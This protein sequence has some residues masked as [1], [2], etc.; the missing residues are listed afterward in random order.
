MK[1]SFDCIPCLVKQTIEAAR[2]SSDEPDLQR[3][4][5]NQVLHYLQEAD[6]EV[7]PPELGKRIFKIMQQLTGCEDPYKDLKFRY[8]KSVMSK[9]AELKR[10]IYLSDDPVYLAA[11]LALSGNFYHLQAEDTQV[12]IREYVDLI[13]RSQFAIDNYFSFLDDLGS[14]RNILYL[15]DN[16]GEIVFDKLFI[17]VLKRF[18][19]ERDHAFTV[20]VRG[21][22]IINDATME[23]ARLI[24]L[25]EVAQVIDNGDNAPAT[26]LHH[27]SE[28]MRDIYDR[29]D[30]V[31]SKGQGNFETLHDEQKLIYFMF[32]V[33][34]PVIA[35]EINVP[36][37]SLIIKK[38]D[39]Y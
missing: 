28:K 13:Q 19:P 18:Y 24:D 34:C 12:T 8:N 21:A 2:L 10:F 20:V 25:E 15:A 4:I 6:F 9:Y 30:L 3:K 33:R 38:S 26:I 39:R 7:T 14:A 22:P 37:G 29:A 1:A 17:E 32:K 31:I 27:V 16:A 36:E 5:L 11:K 23:D 35:S